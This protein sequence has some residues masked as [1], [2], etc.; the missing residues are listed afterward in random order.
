MSVPRT[1]PRPETWTRARRKSDGKPFFFIPSASGAAVYMAAEDGCTCP[2]AQHSRTGD[3]K[4]QAAVRQ[5]QAPV[6]APKPR[7]SY[8]SLFPQCRG[9]HD[10]AD[11]RDGYC[12]RCASEREWQARRAV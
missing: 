6:V 2:A 5:H 10:I 12:D 1:V 7:V 11:G 8:E 9:C 4:H 3:C